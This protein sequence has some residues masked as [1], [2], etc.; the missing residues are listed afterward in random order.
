MVMNLFKIAALTAISLLLSVSCVKEEGSNNPGNNTETGSGTT[1]G[2]DPGKDPGTD[3]GTNPVAEFK[4]SKHGAD[5]P[6]LKNDIVDMLWYEFDIKWA[7]YIDIESSIEWEIVNLPEWLK[8]EVKNVSKNQYEV[9]LVADLAKLPVE[10]NK[11]TVSFKKKENDETVFS[12]ELRLPS[13]E[14]IVNPIYFRKSIDFSEN[15]LL[16]SP[17]E[18]SDRIYSG[19]VVS[20]EGTEL[21]AV[22]KSGNT[23]VVVADQEGTIE[24]WCHITVQEPW[25]AGGDK[26][27]SIKYGFSVDANTDNTRAASIVAVPK[28][29]RSDSFNPASDL[30]TSDK[31]ALRSDLTI[32]STITQQGKP[33]SDITVSG[34]EFRPIETEGGAY[35]EGEV[36]QF[37][38][39][40]I[41][42]GRP[43]YVLNFNEK[44]GSLTARYN[45]DNIGAAQY[46]P[47]EGSYISEKDAFAPLITPDQTDKSS[48]EVRLVPDKI[49]S[50]IQRYLIEVWGYSDLNDPNAMRPTAF[51]YVIYNP[52]N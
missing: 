36:Y 38:R 51:I 49:G 10:G 20:V 43:V 30:F 47:F 27:Q 19:T 15:G 4:L 34:C 25:K 44:N 52:A 42:D 50:G 8:S 7:F 18:D 22:A 5:T 40:D 14:G 28:S 35:K 26:I 6:I 3:P 24:G 17:T 45:G 13:S 1:P 12:F 41:M 46:H 37:L 23:M 21:Y 11:T 2:T 31:S 16:T 9:D 39:A 29:L 32:V 48:F 33:F